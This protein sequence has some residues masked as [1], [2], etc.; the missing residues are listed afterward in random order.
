MSSKNGAIKINILGD[1]SKLTS[2][3]DKADD[4]VGKFSDKVE[5]S[6][7]KM[8]TA[9]GSFVGN[10]GADAFQS[11]ASG[12]GN[13]ASGMLG[14]AEEAAKIARVTNQIVE[15]TGATAWTSGQAIGDLTSK[16]SAKVGVDDE[17]IQAGANVLLTF[18]NVQNAAGEGNDVF[19]RATKSG[20]DLS[21]VLGTDLSSANVMLG[22]ALND[23]LKGLTSLGKAGVTFTAEQQEQIKTL[24][25]HNDTLGAQKIILKEIENQVGGTAEKNAT[26]TDKMTVVWGNLQETLGEKLLPIIEAVSE[27]MSENLP[28]AMEKVTS[29]ID[30]M[31][32]SVSSIVDWMTK[33]KEVLIAVGVTIVAALVPAFVAW[34]VAAG[35]AAI[36]T[37][38]AIAPVLLVA[39]A[40]GLLVYGIIYAYNH[41]QGFHDVVTTVG[42]WLKDV[43]WPILQKTG[44]WLINAIGKAI[45]WITETAIPGIVAGFIWFKENIWPI[46]VEIGKIVWDV[47]VAAFNFIIDVV[48]PGLVRAFGWFSDNVLPI[49]VTVG[50]IIWS[51]VS[52]IIDVVGK[53]VSWFLDTAWPRISSFASSVWG[54]F[55]GIWNTVSTV[56]GWI[57]GAWDGIV[58]FFT[59][60]PSKIGNAASGMWDGIKNAFKSALNW[61]IDKWNNLGFKMPTIDLGPLGKVGGWEVGPKYSSALQIPRFHA[62]GTFN[63]GMG[64]GLALL[65]D[66]E[67][68]RT[69]SQEASLPSGN[70]VIELHFN[71]PVA[72]DS[73]KWVTDQVEQAV[74]MGHRFPRLSAVV[75]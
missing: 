60:L 55:V 62:G 15:T 5:K 47:L 74:A 29:F 57:T 66:G 22:K 43:L 8:S 14:E 46:I 52:G 72:Q 40:I 17:V 41:W 20:L 3:L 42:N 12:V 33:H 44:A 35:S 61:I 70:T 25:A 53:M 51:V 26:A 56:V 30:E 39:A 64:E 6:G 38:A 4:H 31:V 37:L 28:S 2:E 59:G 54:V 34:A 58:T 36:A 63:S 69:R 49:F 24:V 23:P 75:G 1:A 11:L 18:K 19:D 27:W 50:R 45:T 9:W 32:A 48:V 7:G 65:Q 10:L 13:F 67:T 73:I 68:V 21:A 16:L 71:G